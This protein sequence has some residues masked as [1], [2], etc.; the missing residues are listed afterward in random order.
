MTPTRLLSVLVAGTLPLA[1]ETTPT[2]AP[3]APAAGVEASAI[4]AN[5]AGV[6]TQA[7]SGTLQLVS[8]TPIV[9]V[10][11]P[12][13]HCHAWWLVVGR[14]EGSIEG[15]V[16]F[17]E[18]NKTECGPGRLI[19]SG[20]ADGE[21]TWNGRT[22]TIAGQWTT[23]C[24]PDASQPTGASCDGTLNFRGSGEL[25]GVQFHTKS[26]PGWWPFSYTGTAFWQ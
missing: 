8:A 13:G 9:I 21:V 11:T 23:N 1:C 25:E 12:S 26:G 14:Y 19:G 15:L 24:K 3:A 17:H 4:G 5:A 7:I 6:Q 10:P 20:P 16:T 18:Q 22:G 2:T